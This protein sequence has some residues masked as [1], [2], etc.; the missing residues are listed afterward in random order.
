MKN[1]FASKT[2]LAVAAGL[3]VLGGTASLRAD[4]MWDSRHHYQRD[5]YGYWDE[6]HSYHHYIKYGGHNGY[7]DTQGP[8]RVFINVD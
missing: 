1:R 6:H 7:W 3:F 2:L 8:V 5:N 4:G